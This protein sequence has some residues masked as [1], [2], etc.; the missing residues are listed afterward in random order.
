MEHRDIPD[1]E[2]HE[3][4][5][6]S[7]AQ[8]G[9]VYI[10]DG[11]SSGDWDKLGKENLQG[12]SGS[13]DA[14]RILVSGSGGGFSTRE[15]VFSSTEVTHDSQLLVDVLNQILVAISNLQEAVDDLESRVAAL[16]V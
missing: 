4:K 5:G 11:N 14:G 13:E 7:T 15:A 8:V 16:E 3:P 2:R 6:A 1:T 9:T 12:L 10:A